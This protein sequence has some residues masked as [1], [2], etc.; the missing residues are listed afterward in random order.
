M[1]VNS[2]E[3]Q[4]DATPRLAYSLKETA[5]ML[6]ISDKSVRRLIHRGLIRPC[7]ALCHILIP[8]IEIERFLRETR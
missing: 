5:A 1:N 3:G 4:N 8:K 2:A 7:R 6:G